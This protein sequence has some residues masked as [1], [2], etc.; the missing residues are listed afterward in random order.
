MQIHQVDQ[1][2]WKFHPTADITAYE[3]ALV[4]EKA[5]FAANSVVYNT[6]PEEVRRHFVREGDPT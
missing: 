2:P 4:I 1:Y 6:Y 5:N 3:L